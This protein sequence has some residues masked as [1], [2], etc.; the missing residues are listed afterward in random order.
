MTLSV[1]PSAPRTRFPRYHATLFAAFLRGASV[2]EAAAA[3]GISPRQTKRWKSRY[4]V[5][6]EEARANLVDAAQ[7]QLREALPATAE[8]IARSAKDLGDAVPK[9]LKRLLEIIENQAAD[10]TDV[11]LAATALLDASARASAL[12]FDVHAKFSDRFEVE[13]RL[14]NI[15]TRIAAGVGPTNPLPTRRGTLLTF[16]ST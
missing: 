8:N 4:A 13:R 1:P 9:A 16:P 10:L 12:A 14:V 15:E 6:L 3:A 11:R 7:A 2:G 5:E